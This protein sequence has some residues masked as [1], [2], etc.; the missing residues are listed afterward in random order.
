MPERFSAVELTR[1]KRNL[2][3]HMA[4]RFGRHFALRMRK[5]L[6]LIDA[7]AGAPA[8]DD[9]VVPEVL[10]EARALLGAVKVDAAEQD[11]FLR[12]MLRVRFERGWQAHV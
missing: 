11:D 4:Q 7:G 1:V 8:Q 3:R 9:T 10:A 2:E 12:S 5:L 6:R